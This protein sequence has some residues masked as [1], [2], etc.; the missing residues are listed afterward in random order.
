MSQKQ[1]HS[2]VASE[3][4]PKPR[5]GH[6]DYGRIM[7]AFLGILTCG[8]VGAQVTAPPSNANDLEEITVTAQR[9][10]ESL[11]RVPVTMESI[12]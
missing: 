6:R 12:G 3:C 1:Y 9:R 5:G 11:E 10:A 8:G 7:A 2:T 4:A